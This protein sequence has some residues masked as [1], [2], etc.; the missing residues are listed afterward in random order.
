[1]PDTLEIFG[2]PGCHLCEA[3]IQTAIRVR[4]R[5]SFDL[6]LRNI[7]GDAYEFQERYKELIPVV[8]LNGR[9]IARYRISEAE[10]IAAL[11]EASPSSQT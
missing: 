11:Q 7:E 8:L 10:L 6:K 1:M 2:K 9:E 3:V 4:E 5:R